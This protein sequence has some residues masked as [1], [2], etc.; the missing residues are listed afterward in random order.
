MLGLNP[1]RDIITTAF[2]PPKKDINIILF[3]LLMIYYLILL[4]LCYISPHNVAINA[5]CK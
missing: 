4:Y 2:C 3:V 5:F 1:G